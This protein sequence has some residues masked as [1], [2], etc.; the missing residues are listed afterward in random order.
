MSLPSSS[1]ISVVDRGQPIRVLLT[2]ATGFVGRHLYPALASAGISVTCASRSPERAR[3]RFPDRTWVYLDM[4]DPGSI[5]TAMRGCTAAY[6]LIHRIAHH[7]GDR[8]TYPAR[9]RR[10]ASAFAR[11]AGRAGLQRIVY[12]GGVAP[13]QRPSRHLRARLDTGAILRA[14]P[15]ATVELRAAMIIGAGSESWRIVRDLAARLPAMV[16]P[17]W[18]RNHSWPVAIDDVVAALVASLYLERDG[19]FD[20]PG[21]ERLSHIELLRRAAM[22]LRHRRPLSVSVPVLTPRLSSYWIGLISDV[23]LAM[24]RE[25]V[26][27]LQSDLD[28]GG[29]RI[30][31]HLP[32][33]QRLSVDEAM[34]RALAAEAAVTPP[35]RA[36][37]D[38]AARQ[39]ASP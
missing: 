24:A 5:D 7:P 8:A 6:Y 35:P 15:V 36:W 10:G 29:E 20:A 11:A 33:H 9:E 13:R 3:R 17:R 21:P 1:P 2:G 30:W 4:D 32:G 38:A 39:D 18:L 16:L 22:A 23:D 31:A 34:R 26:E 14:G 27:G 25:L 28:P 12:L 37:H 19:W